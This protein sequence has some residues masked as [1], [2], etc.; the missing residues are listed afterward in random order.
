VNVRE[1]REH[2][3]SRESE[4]EREAE[5]ACGRVHP[6]GLA[7]T[8]LRDRREGVVVELGDEQAEADARDDERRDEV[9][10][11]CRAGHDRDQRRD[12]HCEEE[13]A[14][15]DDAARPSPARVL[16]PDQ[17]ADFAAD[18]D[19][20]RRHERFESDSR[21]H[22]AHRR[23]EIVNHSRDRHIH[24]R[25]V[26]DEDEHRHRQEDRELDVTRDGGGAGVRLGRHGRRSEA[27][28]NVRPGLGF[29][30]LVD[31]QIR[32]GAGRFRPA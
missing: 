6:G 8:L 29:H 9:P 23:P 13:E 25:R 2:D 7:H 4:P 1:G 5:R 22:R 3:C 12:S 28:K 26:D 18:Q 21:L 20:C 19:E 31:S 32:Q 16:A 10:A 30:P 17:V 27:A 15:A 24:Q 11:G 14:G